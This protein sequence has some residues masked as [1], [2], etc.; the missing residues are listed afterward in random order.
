MSKKPF[1]TKVAIEVTQENHKEVQQAL[2]DIGCNWYIPETELKEC[3]AS[4]SHLCVNTLG[5]ITMSTKGFDVDYP[6]VQLEDVVANSNR[7]HENRFVK[8]NKTTDKNWTLDRAL[9]FIRLHQQTVMELGW[10]LMLGG[11]V[12]N[13]GEGKDLDLMLYPRNPNP[14]LDGF[15]QLFPNGTTSSVSVATIY[16]IQHTYGPIEFILQDHVPASVK[17]RL[18]AKRNFTVSGVETGGY[19]RTEDTREL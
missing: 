1:E 15:I 9:E 18:P 12:L 14:S 2:F 11:G 8:M 3:G 5:T 17:Y 19:E 10:C 7:L 13:R 4:I 16:T 6:I